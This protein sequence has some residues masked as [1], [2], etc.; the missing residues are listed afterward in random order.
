M[1]TPE[2]GPPEAQ[3]PWQGL[4]CHALAASWGR[5]LWHLSASPSP[6]HVSCQPDR[7]ACRTPLCCC[8]SREK[9]GRSCW[10][11][12]EIEYKEKFNYLPHHLSDNHSYGCPYIIATGEKFSQTLC[13]EAPLQQLHLL[14]RR[15]ALLLQQPRR[16]RRRQPH[17]ASPPQRL[18]SSV[19]RASWPA[20]ASGS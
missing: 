8:C 2:R 18:S 4:R 15:T 11:I 13:L 12:Q 6:L 19:P 7:D 17:T 16:T 1:H 9:H 3:L 14:R 5:V 10:R 20:T